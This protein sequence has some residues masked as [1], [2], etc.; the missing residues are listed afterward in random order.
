MAQSYPVVQVTKTSPQADIPARGENTYLRV[1]GGDVKIAYGTVSAE[2]A[3][4]LFNG[5]GWL[6]PSG[7]TVRVYHRRGEPTISVMGQ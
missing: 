1:A 6:V 7:T 3:M 5:E 4:P 2:D